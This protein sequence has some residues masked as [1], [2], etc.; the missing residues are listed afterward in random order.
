MNAI[1]GFLIDLDGVLYI[2]D[3]VTPGAIK[4]INWLR[5]QGIPFRFI[6]NTTIRSRESISKKIN[7]FGFEVE[8]NEIFSTCTVAASWL[9]QNDFN[10]IHLMVTDNAKIDFANFDLNSDNPDVV[11]V[12][13][14]GSQFNYENLNQA[15]RLVNSG[16]K[17]VALQKNRFWKTAEGLSLDVGAFV[18]ALEYACE[19]E[20]VLIG[21]PNRAYFEMALADM[22]LP[23]S[24]VAMIG[25]D[26]FTDIKG[27]NEAGL[28]TILVKTGKF[29]KTSLEKVDVKP[30]FLIESI[31]ELKS[32]L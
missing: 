4:T 15:F 2:E 8:T 3:E 1:K 16:A 26:I 23:A 18:T 6:T 27:G 24:A 31:S 10:K 12:G 21:K 30:D 28:K 20:A 29:Q 22:Q 13:D 14:I 32:I 9:K 5:D 7:D 17:L 25:D 19:V 11:L